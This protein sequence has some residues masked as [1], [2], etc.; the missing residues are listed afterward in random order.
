MSSQKLKIDDLIK[1]QH[2]YFG[3]SYEGAPR[4]LSPQE[5]NFRLA[6]MLEELTE[7]V[8]AESLADKYDAL[9]DLMVFTLG[10]CERMGLPIQEALDEVIL[11]NL[12]KKLGPNNKRGG[13]KLDLIK[14][15]GWEPA[16]LEQFLQI[17]CASQKRL[18]P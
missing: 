12:D 13:F 8:L 9:I 5:E 4:S 2:R 1:K 10:T 6:A 14:P 3:I 15:E 18:F 16:D 7:F 17:D 11:A